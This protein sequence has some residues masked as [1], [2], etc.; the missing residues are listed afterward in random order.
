MT[1]VDV[2]G[3]GNAI[4]DVITQSDDDFVASQGLEK[5]S[6]TLIDDD[7][8]HQ[9]YDLMPPGVEA[10]GGSAANTMAGIASFGGTSAYIGKVSG[11]ELGGVFRDDMRQTGVT[12]DVPPAEGGPATARC[13]ILVTPDAQRTMST[14]LGVSS[15]LEPDDINPGTVESGQ[16]LF[17]EGYLWDVESAKQAIR[18]AM[19][20]ARSAGRHSALTLSDTFC[21][22]RHYDDFR[23]LVAGRVDV[24][25]A[26]EAELGALYK[27][28]SLDAGVAAVA[29]EVELACI[30]RGDQGSL[31]VRGTE[32]VEIAAVEASAVVDT[33]GAGDQYAAGV[34]FGLARGLDLA[35][36]GRLGSV[37]AAE[38]ISHVGPRPLT[39]LKE[40][41]GF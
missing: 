28:D 29:G 19:D 10:S 12:F 22:E 5:G 30:T 35:E 23:D 31:L 39:S 20:V 14:Y 24:L 18:R 4:V 33:T 7:R 15:L 38:V 1:E 40:L 32:V 37:A 9:L 8:A 16:L 2:V 3:V 26:N 11:D 17:C 25:F 36:C 13:L 27:T 21:V 34:L 6:M 41:A